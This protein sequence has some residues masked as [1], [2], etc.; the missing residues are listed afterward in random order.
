MTIEPGKKGFFLVFTSDINNTYISDLT[1]QEE[2]SCKM[3]VP[4][5][6]IL[7]HFTIKSAKI[8]YL[9]L[10]PFTHLWMRHTPLGTNRV[11]RNRVTYT[12]K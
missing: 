5:H 8:C 10:D 2:I 9:L 12:L 11:K 7:Y 3:E 6:L 1:L 4:L